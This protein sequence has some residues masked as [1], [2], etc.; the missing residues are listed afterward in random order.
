MGKKPPC[1][2]GIGQKTARD[3]L[4]C[5]NQLCCSAQPIAIAHHIDC[6]RAILRNYCAHIKP[7]R[8][9]N[10]AA[11]ADDHRYW[12]MRLTGGTLGDAIR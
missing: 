5:K 12:I 8:R 11:D 3:Q 1:R 9:I 10:G 7:M 6:L 4:A 2:R